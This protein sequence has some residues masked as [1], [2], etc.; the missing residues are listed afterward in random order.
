MYARKSGGPK[1]DVITPEDGEEI[2]DS[3]AAVRFFITLHNST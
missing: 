1:L 3:I 2:P